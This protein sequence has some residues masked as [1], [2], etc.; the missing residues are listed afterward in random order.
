M[1]ENTATEKTQNE[2]ALNCENR[3]L[4]ILL[5][6]FSN[7]GMIKAWIVGTVITVQDDVVIF[8][9]G[10]TIFTRFVEK[11]IPEMLASIQKEF[12]SINKI[13]IKID[14]ELSR[15]H[16]NRLPQPVN[17]ASLA[18]MIQTTDKA[19]QDKLTEAA[20][21]ASIWCGYPTELTRV[22]P[23]FPMKR[24]D[25]SKNHFENNLVIQS[26]NWG[27][28]IYSGPL[29]TT[30]DETVL[31]A[32]LAAIDK[33][34]FNRVKEEYQD[35][36][37]ETVT[38]YTYLG[39]LV[40]LFNF[41]GYSSTENVSEKNRQYFLNTL[42]RLMSAVITLEVKADNEKKPSLFMANMLEHAQWLQ[43]D[44]KLKVTVNPYF[45]EC[46]C[47]GNISFIDVL[48][49]A[50]ISGNIAKSLYRFCQSHREKKDH[51][52]F[53]GHIQVLSEVLNMKQDSPQREIKRQLKNA[54]QELIKQKVL[55]PTSGID[56]RGIATLFRH[57]KALPEKLS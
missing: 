19:P 46:Y 21:P 22:S 9:T 18:T 31:L 2:Q 29:L 51:S 56:A 15:S 54:I 11:H 1:L 23:F 14:E 30:D 24:S 50:E 41:M 33:T 3:I 7:N 34:T 25:A 32:V 20:A 28:I 6:L 8:K 36:N 10:G 12:S 49:R 17:M 5:S 44:K 37:N 40:P 26:G 47:N 35:D 48:K 13:E 57:N 38:T 4:N 43:K 53:R 45:Y 27:R 39:P 55:L 16:K 42:K 52:I